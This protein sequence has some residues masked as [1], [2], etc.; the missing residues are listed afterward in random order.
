M[1]VKTIKPEAPP[2]YLTVERPPKSQALQSMT[3]FASQNQLSDQ[4]IIVRAQ[5][6]NATFHS[7]GPVSF[8]K[9]EWTEIRDWIDG[10]LNGRP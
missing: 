4:N 10:R 9:E 1:S 2:P 3:Q 6:G 7:F 5:G 8:S